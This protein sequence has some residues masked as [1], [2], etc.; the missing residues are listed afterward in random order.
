[1]NH[2]IF[3]RR[4]RRRQ[5]S[6]CEDFKQVSKRTWDLLR[7]AKDFEFNIG[8]ETITDIN[9]LELKIR[10]PAAIITKQVSRYN[11]SQ[12]GADWIW[13]IVGRT[14]ATFV[15]YV[16]AKKLFTRSNRYESLIDSTNPFHQVDNLIRN[17]FYYNILGIHMYPIYVF[18]NYFN[19]HPRKITCN[20]INVMDSN[21]AGCSYADAIQIRALIASGKDTL[22]D[23]YHIQYSL[24]CLVCCSNVSNLANPGVVNDLANSFFNRIINVDTVNNFMRQRNNPDFSAT[25]LI[26]E[27]PPEIIN[28]IIRGEQI[29]DEIFADLNIGKIVILD[30]RRLQ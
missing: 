15:L 21:L 29:N 8:E 9:L 7:N 11:E 10:Q 27:R 30:E 24:S 23:L 3:S 28:Q 26:L 17:Q 5:L 2:L 18:Y 14:G 19:N 6:L 20:C 25:N 13:A 12:L 1:M 4:D 22:D 16:Q